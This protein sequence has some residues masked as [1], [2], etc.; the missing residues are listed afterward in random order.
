MDTYLKYIELELDHM[1]SQI[2]NEVNCPDNEDGR[3]RIKQLQKES[4]EK[5]RHSLV[6]TMPMMQKPLH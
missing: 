6:V 5:G 1:E 2:T 3:E 4:Q